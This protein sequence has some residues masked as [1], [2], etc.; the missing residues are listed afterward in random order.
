VADPTG[1]KGTGRGKDPK[2]KWYQERGNAE[3]EGLNEPQ[4]SRQKEVAPR[5]L[6]SPQTESWKTNKG[7]HDNKKQKGTNSI[8]KRR[9][10]KSEQR[11][12]KRGLNE[13]K[14]WVKIL[15]GGQGHISGQ[16]SNVGREST[17]CGKKLR[18]VKEKKRI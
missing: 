14:G 8:E 18:R 12:N 6:I 17:L 16:F 4:Q 13:R 10:R 7:K 2:V 3:E 15:W 5:K 1:F 11:S 9:F